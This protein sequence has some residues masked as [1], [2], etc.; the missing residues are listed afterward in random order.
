MSRIPKLSWSRAT[1]WSR[2]NAWWVGGGLAVLAVAAGG[3]LLGSVVA[4]DQSEAESAREAGY[5]E[6][7]ELAFERARTITAIRG[8][9]VGRKRGKL[10]GEETGTREGFDLAGGQAG[11]T[12]ARSQADA[13]R[14]AELAAEAEIAQRRG[15]CGTIATAPRICPTDAELADYRAALRAATKPAKKKRAKNG[16]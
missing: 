5:G 8:A 12:N 9:A 14:A 16:R 2:A 10:A 11:L 4:S 3:Y 13:A 1:A 6:A 7:Y 15:N